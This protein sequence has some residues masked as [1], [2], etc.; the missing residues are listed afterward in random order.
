M[1]LLGGYFGVVPY[2]SSFFGSDK[3]KNLG[4]VYS[5]S[6]YE[7]QIK[8]AG[9]ESVVSYNVSSPLGVDFS[10]KVEVKNTFTREEISARINYSPWKYMP[11]TNVQVNFPEDGVV[12]FSANL[13]V[14]KLPSF[15]EAVG[16]SEVKKEDIDK[17]LSYVRF[18]HNPPIYAKAKVSVSE[19]RANIHLLSAQVGRLDVPLENYDPD[20]ILKSSVEKIFSLVPGFY[21]KSVSFSPSGLYFEGTSP[22]KGVIWIS[23][24]IF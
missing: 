6:D 11:I 22:S 16:F 10:G 21:A 4:V 14:D 7:S 19:N 13:L 18:I 17:A 15:L 2:T 3:P 24:E 5:K 23:S 1:L 20:S 9:Y 12:E 8:K